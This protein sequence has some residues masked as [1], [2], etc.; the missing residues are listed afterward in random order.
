MEKKLLAKKTGIDAAA[1]D[2]SMMNFML[3]RAI[4]MYTDASKLCNDFFP[5]SN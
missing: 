5:S 3:P 2:Q 4:E 1:F